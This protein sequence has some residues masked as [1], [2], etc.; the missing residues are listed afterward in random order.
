MLVGDGMAFW[1]VVAGREGT[2]MNGKLGMMGPF[3]SRYQAEGRAEQLE[4][5]CK[6][7]SLNTVDPNRASRMLKAKRARANP[8]EW[9]E[10][11]TRVRRLKKWE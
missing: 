11:T 1:I 6:V 7:V 5:D 4:S 10:A 9:E 2:R 3:G 8:E